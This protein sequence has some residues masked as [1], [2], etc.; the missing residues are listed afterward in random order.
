[1]SGIE[2]RFF[3]VFDGRRIRD[4]KRITPKEAAEMMN[5]GEQQVRIMIQNGKIPGAFCTGK[6]PRRTYYIYEEQI[7]S[8]I[9]G[10]G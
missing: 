7:R 6:L 1:M 10:K 8:L 9:S 4:M 5:C 3:D 2:S